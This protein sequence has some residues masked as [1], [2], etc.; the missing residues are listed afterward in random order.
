MLEGAG[1]HP[2]Y[3]IAKAHIIRFDTKPI[4]QHSVAPD[5]VE[6][7]LHLLNRAASELESEFRAMIDRSSQGS[8]AQAALSDSIRYVQAPNEL[9][10][11]T[12]AM[13]SEGHVSA[14]FAVQEVFDAFFRNVDSEFTRD[15]AYESLDVKNRLLKI[16]QPECS[17]VVAQMREQIDA[18]TEP[19]IIFIENLSPAGAL[20]LE[21]FQTK[22]GLIKGLIIKNTSHIGH[23]DLVLRGLRCPVVGSLDFAPLVESGVLAPG[24]EVIIDGDR[25]FVTF[26]PSPEIRREAYERME[27]LDAPEGEVSLSSHAPRTKDGVQMRLLGDLLSAGQMKEF[28]ARRVLAIGLVRTEFSVLRENRW[29]EEDE[30]VREYKETLQG[31]S[32]SSVSLRTYDF[33]FDKI[34]DFLND[35]NA[36][37]SGLR[38]LRL[39]LA[40]F[41]DELHTQLRAMIQAAY[42]V[43]NEV[44]IIFPMV[45]NARDMKNA[46]RAY[47]SAADALVAEGRIARIPQ[48]IKLG[49]MIETSSSVELI[50]QILELCD[51]VS[52]GTNDLLL[53]TL[54]GDLNKASGAHYDPA[55][56]S[57][58]RK[59]VRA[60]RAAGK[61]VHICGEMPCHPKN[62]PLLIGIGAT[63][64]VV[65]F[66][67]AGEVNAK[68]ARCDSTECAELVQRMIDTGDDEEAYH[69]RNEFLKT[70]R[71]QHDE[72][73]K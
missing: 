30:L 47:Q 28:I 21:D 39:M 38:G 49:A 40:L 50:D 10:K 13:I 15:R 61:E 71:E 27:L 6:R 32:P 67:S 17:N 1:Q 8:A 53:S 37:E 60:A 45:L 14:A 18:I 68:I 59:V 9:M 23:Q 63:N 48:N 65:N 57:C 43:G 51:M 31:A 52:I 55:F 4:S 72:D 73:G 34:P 29:L 62:I 3:A 7:E 22:T 12:R 42:D 11:N 36:R 25:G 56:L 70:L 41:E 66:Q 26:D 33:G 44:R 35:S 2:G 64:L 24:R 5:E 69:M 20:Q 46:Q 19:V 16:L 54:D 58:A